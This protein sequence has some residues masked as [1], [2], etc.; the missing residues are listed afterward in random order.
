MHNGNGDGTGQRQP[1]SESSEH[2]HL[3]I[4]LVNGYGP[5]THAL[6]GLL[7]LDGHKVHVARTVAEALRLAKEH[8]CDLLISDTTLPDGSGVELFE[9]I[10][11]MYPLVGFAMTADTQPECR[12]ECERA[13]FSRFLLKP[14]RFHDVFAGIEGIGAT[15]EP[16]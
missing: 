3:C 2:S 12:Q 1:M 11:A 5:G 10:K 4:L 13:G 6:C 7:E 9:Q 8:H 14:V 15:R 16:G